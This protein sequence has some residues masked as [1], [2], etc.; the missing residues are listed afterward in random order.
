MRLIIGL[1]AATLALAQGTTPKQ[2]PSE[3]PVHS[4]AGEIGIGA[5][6]MVHSFG[7][8]EEMYLAQNYLVVEVAL[9]PPKDQTL[10]VDVSHFALHLN[11]KKPALTPQPPSMVAA[12]LSHPEWQQQRTTMDAQAGPVGVGTGYPPNRPPFPGAPPTQPRYP[13][14]PRAPDAGP[15]GGIEK[16]QPA[17]P[18]EV[19]V[20]TALPVNPH[21]GPI[22]G[23]LYFPYTGKTS[24]IKSLELVWEGAIL[25][26]R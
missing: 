1:M 24:S 8:G 22:S 21:R 2:S 18:A 9:F 3:Y 26:L 25:K 23:F 14:P 4:E 12:S 6:Y 11:G 13:A 5:E 10:T 16:K 17:N 20:Q 15:P 7:A 19:L